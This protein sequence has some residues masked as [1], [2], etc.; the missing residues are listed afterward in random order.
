[1]IAAYYELTQFLALNGEAGVRGKMPVESYSNPDLLSV[2]L[3]HLMKRLLP[4]WKMRKSN[5]I[6]KSLCPDP[7]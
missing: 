6:P 3:H 4:N 1:M 2:R 7:V 5:R